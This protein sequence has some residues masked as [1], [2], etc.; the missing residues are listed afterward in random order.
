MTTLTSRDT[1]TLVSI[2][3]LDD[4]T[5]INTSD[6][7]VVSQS[8]T[9]RK[10]SVNNLFQQFA[11]QS[12]LAATE[13]TFLNALGSYV[14]I[15]TAQNV[16]GAKT[17]T[18]AVHVPVATASTNPITK[19][20][21]DAH[22][23]AYNGTV[24]SL[25]THV[26]NT[27]NPHNTTAAQV[28]NSTA[29]WNANKLQ[30]RNVSTTAPA[31]GQALLYNTSTA[32]WAPGDVLSLTA[33]AQNIS[34]EKTFLNTSYFK[35]NAVLDVANGAEASLRLQNAGFDRFRIVKTTADDFAINTYNTDGTPRLTN[36]L[37]IN[38]TS[39]VVDAA[40]G[41]TSITPSASDNSNKVATTAYVK[42]VKGL[43]RFY[44]FQAN[45]SNTVFSV[46]T[47]AIP[48]LTQIYF[49]MSAS[50]YVPHGSVVVVALNGNGAGT[51][52]TEISSE[53]AGATPSTAAWT[54][55]SPFSWFTLY[56][57][58]FQFDSIWGDGWMTALP[59]SRTALV[60][61]LQEFIS[62]DATNY[63]YRNRKYRNFSNV[64][65]GAT[66]INTVTV[67]HY[68]RTAPGTFAASA[69][70]ATFNIQLHA[71]VN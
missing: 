42:G 64:G 71:V 11:S 21:F 10:A 32:L 39:G 38:R 22:V 68:T 51:V 40:N 56:Q 15:S 9:V 35:A 41:F 53:N 19:G 54:E 1:V 69:F 2:D 52:T 30:G 36:A 3:S 14:N 58:T 5:D 13:A 44:T 29:Q 4:V 7:L 28:G 6:N 60:S 62:F 61:D 46:D 18:G 66:R 33:G 37:S 50:S 34:G 49:T 25:G 17:F 24:T 27:G 67:A 12:E 55:L 20:V 70:P 26:A 65:T 43:E 16:T 48:S 31:N 47:S 45:G 59:N 8:G 57:S 63:V 23:T